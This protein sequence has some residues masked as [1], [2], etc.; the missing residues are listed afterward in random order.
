MRHTSIPQPAYIDIKCWFLFHV[1]VS[2]STI[3]F[4]YFL[5]LSLGKLRKDIFIQIGFI[6]AGSW[7][8][9]KA[10]YL[11]TQGFGG[12]RAGMTSFYSRSGYLRPAQDSSY[13]C[14]EI[15]W[16]LNLSGSLFGSVFRCFTS[17]QSPSHSDPIQH[18]CKVKWQPINFL[19]E[20]FVSTRK[21]KSMILSEHASKG[22]GD[23]LVEEFLSTVE[24]NLLVSVMYMRLAV[25]SRTTQVQGTI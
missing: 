13:F 22:N 23:K 3:S 19:F 5:A 12:Q 6:P 17:L 9:I 24:Y 18:A 20:N 7:A 21:W 25:E 11:P 2:M 10:G 4:C 16:E 8:G 14:L 15:N 1:I